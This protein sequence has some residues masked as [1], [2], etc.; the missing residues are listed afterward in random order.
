MGEM[1]KCGGGEGEK[2]AWRRRRR[3]SKA[4]EKRLK[5]DKKK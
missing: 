3:G 1:T 5:K 4:G 2:L